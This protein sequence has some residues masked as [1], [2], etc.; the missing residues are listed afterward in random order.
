[1][2]NNELEKYALRLEGETVIFP[3][4][5]DYAV[6]HADGTVNMFNELPSS[7]RDSKLIE[8]YVN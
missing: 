3:N 6:K 1:M 8:L 2:N 4:D 7:Q 5:G